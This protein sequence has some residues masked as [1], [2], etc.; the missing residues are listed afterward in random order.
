MIPACSRFFLALPF[1]RCPSGSLQAS[2]RRRSPYQRSAFPPPQQPALFFFSAR[3]IPDMYLF[4]CFSSP[5]T[6]SKSG[7]CPLCSLP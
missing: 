6:L 7:D 1:S 4:V 2:V 5:D 3:V